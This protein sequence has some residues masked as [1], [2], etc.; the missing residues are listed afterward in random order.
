MVTNLLQVLS[1]VEVLVK[2]SINER[3]AGFIT[4]VGIGYQYRAARRNAR[5]GVTRAPNT[6]TAAQHKAIE[7]RTIAIIAIFFSNEI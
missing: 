1:E 4:Q 2:E 7:P 3:S 5:P 6:K